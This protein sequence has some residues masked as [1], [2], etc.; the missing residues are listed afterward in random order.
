MTPILHQTYTAQ[1]AI[2]AFDGDDSAEILCNGQFVI[3]LNAVLCMFIIGTLE[4]ESHFTSPSNLIWKPQRLDYDPTDKIPWLPT[5]AREVW[6]ADRKKK[7]REHYIFVRLRGD[8]RFVYA[9]RAHLGS[10]GDT[11]DGKD[12]LFSL[13]DKL[14]RDVWLRIGGYP[15]WSIEVNHK[16]YRVDMNDLSTFSQL[17]TELDH[18][19]YSHLIMTRYEEDCLSIFFNDRRGWPEYTSKSSNGVLHIKDPVYSGE[20]DAIEDFNCVCGIS[21]EAPANQTLPRNFAIRI[22]I[23]YFSTGQFPTRFE[24]PNQFPLNF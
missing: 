12:A 1:E 5:K 14:P 13:Y 4:S 22:A 21:L 2:A 24:D 23:E 6:Q 18:A 20:R 10:Y 16:S 3:L 11:K 15:G 8:D 7:L 19:E 9:G 17:L